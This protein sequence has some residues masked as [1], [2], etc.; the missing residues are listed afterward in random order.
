MNHYTKQW[1]TATPGYII[2][3]VDQSNS[4]RFDLTGG[5]TKAIFTAEVINQTITELIASNAS[6]ES[7]KNRVFVSL[8]GYHGDNDVKDLRSN[9]LSEY[10]D[11]P[12]RVEKFTEQVNDGRGG[13]IA[14]NVEL[15]VFI[16]PFFE[17]LTPMGTAFE[18]TERV[19]Q[20]W[21]KKKPECPAPVIINISDGRPEPDDQIERTIKAANR[22]MQMTTDDGSPLI[23]N[24]HI[25][26]NSGGKEISFP[27]NEYDIQD[28]PMAKLLY[29]VS[30]KVP[31]L[32]KKAAKAAELG[33][34]GENAKGFIANA[35]PE[36][37]VKFINFGSSG[38]VDRSSI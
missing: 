37:L 32:Y 31:E 6:G 25:Q 34:L 15:P 30:S 23:F 14:M 19:I 35:S 10:A 22:I 21:I 27:T 20:E 1:S 8:I 11:K 29:Q 3:L 38:G 36:T 12:I 7:V 17:G 13:K 5:K 26:E 18:F 33:N 4:M 16:E 9:Y 24:V 2:F 28:D